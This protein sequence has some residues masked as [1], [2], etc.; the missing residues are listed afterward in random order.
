MIDRTNTVIAAQAG[1][2]GVEIEVVALNPRIRGG[3][4]GVGFR[5]GA[6]R[7]FPRR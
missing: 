2:Q 7:D 4:D 3:D 6:S 1:I 5:R